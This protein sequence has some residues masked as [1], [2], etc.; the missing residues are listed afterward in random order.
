MVKTYNIDTDSKYFNES[1]DYLKYLLCEDQIVVNNG[2]W[3]KSWP[4]DAITIAVNCN[5]VFAWGCS[6]AEPVLHGDLE[7]LAKAHAKDEVWGIAAWCV[8]RRKCMPQ[9]PVA[10]AMAKAGYDLNKLVKGEE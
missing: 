6:D 9:K 8:K 10:E 3:D 5:D 7:E 2:W 1:E 4:Q